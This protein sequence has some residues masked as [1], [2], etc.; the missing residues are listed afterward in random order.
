[1]KS[2]ITSLRVF[3]IYMMLVPGIGLMTIP[4]FMLDFNGLSHDTHLW[5]A[6]VVGL[7]AFNIGVFQYYIAKY[8]IRQLYKL[9]AMLRYFAASVFVLLW[10][11]GEA[12]IAILLFA[13]VDFVGATW[14]LI[15]AINTKK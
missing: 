14:T 11:T 8:R 10:V 13:L 1:M 6:R 5:T 9:T 4:A 7:L 2:I 12:E 15:T 3:S